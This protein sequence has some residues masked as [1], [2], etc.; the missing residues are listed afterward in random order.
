VALKGQSIVA[1]LPHADF[2]GR[3]RSVF[4]KVK[5]RG[6]VTTVTPHDI[7]LSAGFCHVRNQITQVPSPHTL[8]MSKACL[9]HKDELPFFV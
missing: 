7:T 5:E 2:D 9:T 4:V 3:F 1:Q 6:K 8:P